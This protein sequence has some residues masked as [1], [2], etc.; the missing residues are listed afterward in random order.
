[1]GAKL[2]G[3]R[4][5]KACLLWGWGDQRTEKTS[6]QMSRNPEIR[7]NQKPKAP[8]TP[9]GEKG[10]TTRAGQEGR[11]WWDEENERGKKKG[12]RNDKKIKKEKKI[13]KGK[14]A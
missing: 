3:K 14:V 13:R 11:W 5:T 1:M 10:I 4:T 6:P 9:Y 2:A 12:K 7:L 8:S